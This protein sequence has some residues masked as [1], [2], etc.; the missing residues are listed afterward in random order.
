MLE[1][2]E[3]NL[4]KI[5]SQALAQESWRS[6]E[7]LGEGH[8]LSLLISHMEWAAEDSYSVLDGSSQRHLLEYLQVIFYA[9][10]LLLLVALVTVVANYKGV[11]C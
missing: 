1:M 4:L 3:L 11:Y 10:R 9:P 2:Q 6:E 7:I 5:F 8:S